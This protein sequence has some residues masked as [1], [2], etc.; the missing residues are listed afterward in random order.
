MIYIE[1]K[2]KSLNSLV[3]KYSTAKIIDVTSKSID[4]NV[5]FSPF[6]PHGGIPVP[7][8][9]QSSYSVEGIWQGLKIFANQDIDISKFHIK[10]MKGIKRSSRTLGQ[11]IGHRNGVDGS[12]ILDYISARKQ[13]Y[14]PSYLFILDNYLQVEINSIIKILNE[15][16]IVF[17][18]YEINEDIDN[19]RSPL[20]HASILKNYIMKRC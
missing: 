11:I 14:L 16:D 17:L 1:S 18:D 13:I 2:K 9:Q 6:Y 7:Y 8:S 5:K 4:D 10:T 19:V 15:R 20:S 12:T 3:L